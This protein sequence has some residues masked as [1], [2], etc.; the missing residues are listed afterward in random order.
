MV[1]LDRE[2]LVDGLGKDIK[3]GGIVGGVLGQSHGDRESAIVIDGAGGVDPADCSREGDDFFL[4]HS[5]DLELPS[6]E[7]GGGGRRVIDGSGLMGTRFGPLPQALLFFLGLFGEAVLL[8][9]GG[10]RPEHGAW[11]GTMFLAI[12]MRDWPWLCRRKGWVDRK[13]LALVAAL[14]MLTVWSLVMNCARWVVLCNDHCGLIMGY[15]QVQGLLSLT[16]FNLVVL[17]STLPLNGALL[18]IFDTG[19][20]PCPSLCRWHC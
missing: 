3:E 19:L 13:F 20:L 18:V 8:F 2:G 10:A 16:L 7:R 4:S 14:M 9:T 12:L 15:C 6:L 17:S 11:L 5:V 1:L